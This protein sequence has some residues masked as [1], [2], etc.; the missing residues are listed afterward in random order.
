MSYYALIFLAAVAASWHCAG[1][2]GGFACALA[3]SCRGGDAVLRQLLYNVGRATSYCFLGAVAGA[4]T[5]GICT[6]MPG[7]PP[8]ETVQ[9][10]LAVISGLLIV[11]I[12]VQFFGIFRRSRITSGFGGE[13]FA[14]V[15]RDLHRS[16][17]TVAPLAFGVFNGFLPCPLVYGFLAQAASSGNAIDGVGIMAAFG[18]GTF[19][20]MLA[21]GSLG[22][23]FGERTAPIV[24]LDWRNRAS[25]VAGGLF[26]LLGLITLARGL[27]PLQTHGHPI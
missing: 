13:M 9:R 3:G 12:G 17:S 7:T 23:W 11:V 25:V 4:L 14:K 2:C 21:M 5:V 27:L 24:G 26:I 19:P 10:V 22:R 6:A 1:M 8:I 16:R 15:L 20:A 18:L